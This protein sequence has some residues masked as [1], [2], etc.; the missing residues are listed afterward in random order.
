M[1][2]LHGIVRECYEEN[3][4]PNCCPA[5]LTLP[6][7]LYV[8]ISNYTG[9]VGQRIDGTLLDYNGTYVLTRLPGFCSYYI[10]TWEWSCFI[11]LNPLGMS[12][13][14]QRVIGRLE[15]TGYIEL[16]MGRNAQFDGVCRAHLLYMASPSTVTFCGTGVIASGQDGQII[17][18]TRGIP[19]DLGATGAEGSFDW[20]ISA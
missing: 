17:W 18:D 13:G 12:L 4:P 20:E 2:V 16:F 1:H 14:V 8:T 3:P 11:G 9:P 5:G 10:G 6:D 7:E 19:T 15:P